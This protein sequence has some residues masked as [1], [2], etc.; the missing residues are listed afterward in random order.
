MN[1]LYYVMSFQTTEIL[2]EVTLTTN[3]YFDPSEEEVRNKMKN[4]E[5]QIG[6][7]TGC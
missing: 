4:Q 6:S 3:T 5:S 2:S 1:L 7:Y